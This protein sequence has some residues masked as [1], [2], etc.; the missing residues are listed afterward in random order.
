MPGLLTVARALTF[1]ILAISLASCAANTVYQGIPVA[2]LTDEQLIAELESAARGFGIEVNRSMYL[3]AVRPEPAYVLTSSTTTFSGSAN[4]TYNAYVM[5]VGYGAAVSG[6]AS[7]TVSGMATT[8]YQ[9]TDVRAAERLGNALATAISQSRQEAYRRRGLEVMSEYQLRVSMRR[10]ETER[11]IQEYFAQNPDLQSRRTLVAAVAPW[12]ASEGHP[13][14]RATLQRTKDIIESLSRGDGLTGRWYG[15]FAQTNTT[16]QGEVFAFSE[17]VRIDLAQQG[18]TLT[19][20]GI[21]GTSEIVELTGHVSQRDITAAVA[22]TT[23]AIN[24]SLTAIAAPSQITGS[25][26]GFGAGVRMEGTFT[27]LR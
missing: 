24:V 27:L 5:P 15:M 25:F 1:G 13:D 7:G 11:I 20:R 14:A 12:A 18:T 6:S 19:G 17:F 16:A 4:A 21:L 23:S 10:L 8:R 9:Y 3:M 26:T 2:T 22:N